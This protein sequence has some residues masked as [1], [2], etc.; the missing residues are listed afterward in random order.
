MLS[1][2]MYQHII[3]VNNISGFLGSNMYYKKQFTGTKKKKRKFGL[4]CLMKIEI[5]LIVVK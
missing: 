1:H 3:F 4:K 2:S 5:W